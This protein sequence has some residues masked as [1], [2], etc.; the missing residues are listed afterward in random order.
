[1]VDRCCIVR[2]E[3]WEFVELWMNIRRK[4]NNRLQN[5]MMKGSFIRKAVPP[6]QFVWDVRSRCF[7]NL[8]MY[9][10][11]RST[12]LDCLHYIGHLMCTHPFKSAY[13]AL[14]TAIL[15]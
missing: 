6:V 5:N 8:P 1:M 12:E 2:V 10:T 9:P 4:S 3:L 7:T 13:H 14:M 15:A 11:L